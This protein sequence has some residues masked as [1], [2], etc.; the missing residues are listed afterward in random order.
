M[1]ICSHCKQEKDIEDF[2]KDRSS[3]DGHNHRCRDCTKKFDKMPN[4]IASRRKSYLSHEHCKEYGKKYGKSL[5][6]RFYRIKQSAKQRKLEFTLTIDFFEKNW[7]KKCFYCGETLDT[8]A[9]DRVDNGKGY[10]EDNVV[11]CCEVCNW[12][13]LDLSQ[14]CFVEH[15]KQIARTN[16]KMEG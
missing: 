14:K 3:K 8:V 4:I 7:N 11:V 16:Y 13:K 1:K 12:M 6:G 5:K 2:V 9:F 15:C 10:T